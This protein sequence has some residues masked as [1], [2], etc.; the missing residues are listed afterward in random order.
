MNVNT[1]HK[2]DRNLCG[3]PVELKEGVARVSLTASEPMVA[4]ELGLVHG[5]FI[6]GLADYAAM[7]AVNHPNVVLA[8]AH[9]D[10]LKP[11]KVGDKLIAEARITEQEKNKALVEVIVKKSKDMVFSGKFFCVITRH[12]V[13]EG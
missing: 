13:L 5:G 2:I 9:V 4:D 1:H 3:T 12:H 7:L 8:R 6:F 10:F 11:V